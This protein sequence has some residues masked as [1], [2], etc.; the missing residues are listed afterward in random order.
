M[1]VLVT[2]AGG[3]I[4]SHLV[5]RCKADGHFVVG[6]DRKP[7]EEWTRGKRSCDYDFSRDILCSDLVYDFDLCYHLAADARIQPSFNDPEEYVR[8]NVLGTACVLEWCRKVK[9]RMVYAGSSTADSDTSLNVYATTK[10]QGEQ[11]CRTWNRCFGVSVDIAR[12]YNVYGPRQVE[13]GVWATVIGI[14]ERQYRSGEKL[15]VT[16]DGLQRRDFTHVEDI[17]DGLVKI[18]DRGKGGAEVYSLGTGKN[19]SILEV[20]KM[21]CQ[22]DWIEFVPRR[23]GEARET[24]ADYGKAWSVLGW[25]PTRSLEDY[26]ARVLE[27]G[28]PRSS[29]MTGSV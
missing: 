12:F 24:R 11:L 8:N 29:S 16:G 21:F 5:D 23:R 17:V 13:E 2:G 14:F 6:V 19:Y 1:R 10:I 4:G 26:V 27:A 9:A 20:A 28:T 22:P 7:L 18:A 3:F 15:T 25:K